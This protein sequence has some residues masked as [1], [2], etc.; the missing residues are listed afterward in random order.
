[1]LVLPGLLLGGIVAWTASRFLQSQLYSVT[2]NDPASYAIAAGLLL[3]AA[4]LACLLPARRA[5][6]VNPIEALRTE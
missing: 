6:R 5:T 1:M 2:R 4:I 3:L